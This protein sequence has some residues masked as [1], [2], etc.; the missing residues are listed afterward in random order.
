MKKLLNSVSPFIML[1]IPLF[2][3][4]AI[5]FWNSNTEISSEKFRASYS[6]QVPTLKGVIKA[7]F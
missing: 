1:L 3:G 6:F 2:F 4:I 7:F 5:M